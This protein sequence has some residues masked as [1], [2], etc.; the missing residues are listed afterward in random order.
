MLPD[1][2]RDISLFRVLHQIDQ[3]L[4]EECRQAGC[5]F[6]R[7][8]LHYGS[9]FRK[10]RGGPEDIP[11]EYKKR[12]SL[13]CAREEC[14]RRVLPPS[15]LFMGR[16]VYWQAVILVAMTLHQRRPSGFAVNRLVR[17]FSIPRNTLVRWIQ[18]FRAVFPI[19]AQWQRLR[20][21]VNAIVSNQD[22]PGNLVEH[23]LTHSSPP[24]TGLLDCLRFLALGQ[25]R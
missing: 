22:L 10:P 1:L 18:Y 19:N 20:G 11:E 3:D 8:P 15:C 25:A 6:C 24:S 23:F 12:L 5:P 7:G 17:M 14:R 2:L 9:Y 21:R 13:C 16:K 4:A